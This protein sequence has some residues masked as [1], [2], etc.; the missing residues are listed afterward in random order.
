M[1][2]VPFLARAIAALMAVTPEVVAG[3]WVAGWGLSLV[4]ITGSGLGFWLSP[5][6]YA[7]PDSY[8][9]ILKLALSEARLWPISD[10]PSGKSTRPTAVQTDENCELEK[11][12]VGLGKRWLVLPASLRHN[13]AF[14]YHVL[15]ASSVFRS[16]QSLKVRLVPRLHALADVPACS[17]PVPAFG[18]ILRQESGRLAVD[19]KYSALTRPESSSKEWDKTIPAFTTDLLRN[20]KPATRT[21]LINRIRVIVDTHRLRASVPHFIGFVGEENAGK[22]TFIRVR[23]I[24]V[25]K[26]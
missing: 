26:T 1:V 5:T 4:G 23:P 21:N 13:L 6:G 24:G 18:L 11:E 19:F 15:S 14:R 9:A 25:L 20:T 17:C 12:L 22:S 2:G 3:T 10:T 8:T 7:M 16:E